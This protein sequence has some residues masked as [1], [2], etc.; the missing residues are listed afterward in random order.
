MYF[1]YRYHHLFRNERGTISPWFS[2]NSEL[3]LWVSGDISSKCVINYSRLVIIF[4]YPFVFVII[5][6]LQTQ[7]NHCFKISRKMLTNF[8]RYYMHS[9]A[10]IIFN[11]LTTLLLFLWLQVWSIRL[12]ICIIWTI[13]ITLYVSNMSEYHTTVICKILM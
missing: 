11:Y 3:S 4:T 10:W 5:H 7:E 8:P 13:C 1:Y 12:I 9:G 6:Q 2:Q